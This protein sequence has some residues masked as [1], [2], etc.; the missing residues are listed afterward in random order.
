[1]SSMAYNSAAGLPGMLKE[2]TRHF[3]QE[4]DPSNAS[5]VMRNISACLELSRML[6]TSLGPQGRCKLV[7]NH[8]EKLMVTSD[9]ASILKEIQVEHPGGAAA[10]SG[11]SETRR[12]IR[13]QH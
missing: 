5:V 8:L 6:S 9:C 2:G 3:S 7:V 1:M 11:L 10:R 13:R 4:D 12:R